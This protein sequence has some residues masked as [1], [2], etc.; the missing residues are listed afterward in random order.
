MDQRVLIIDGRD[1]TTV[2]IVQRI[3]N[4]APPPIQT[5]ETPASNPLL[6]SQPDSRPIL[7]QQNQTGQGKT[8]LVNQFWKR[9]S[10]DATVSELIQ[11]SSRLVIGANEFIYDRATFVNQSKVRSALGLLKAIDEFI[12]RLAGILNS[13]PVYNQPL[14]NLSEFP[15][16]AAMA[17]IRRDLVDAFCSRVA[18][19]YGK[20]RERANR[21]ISEMPLNYQIELTERINSQL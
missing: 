17:E 1:D 12:A 6:D 7:V 9:A 8:A 13:S 5:G 4:K 18:P 11:Q 19:M 3:L 16:Y 21:L 10:F 20:P 15:Q 2:E 14:P